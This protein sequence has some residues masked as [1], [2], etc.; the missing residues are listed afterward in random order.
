MRIFKNEISI[1][2]TQRNNLLLAAILVNILNGILVYGISLEMSSNLYYSQ[3]QYAMLFTTCIMFLG[4]GIGGWGYSLVKKVEY[5]HINIFIK[6]WIVTIIFTLFVLFEWYPYIIKYI[7]YIKLQKNLI[8]F[9]KILC[10]GLI[11]FPIFFVEGIL[12]AAL[13]CIIQNKWANNIPILAATSTIGSAFGYVLGIF[14]P[15]MP[16]INASIILSVVLLM[17]WVIFQ[18]KRILYIFLFIACILFLLIDVDSFIEKIRPDDN[19]VYAKLQNGKVI[20]YDWSRFQKSEYILSGQG[21]DEKISLTLNGAMQVI[22]SKNP[23]MVKNLGYDSIYQ[24]DIVKGKDVL[25]IGGGMGRGAELAYTNGAATIDIVDIE[26]SLKSKYHIYKEYNQNI[27]EKDNVNFIIADGR[28]I[29]HKLNKK[30][31]VIVF[32]GV[33]NAAA[34]YSLNIT[35]EGYLY[36]QEAMESALLL[37]KKDGIFIDYT[38]FSDKTIESYIKHQGLPKN[39]KAIYLYSFVSDKIAHLDYYVSLACVSENQTLLSKIKS[40]L[41][42]EIDCNG[43]EV[44]DYKQ[45]DILNSS[46]FPITDDRPF[47][48]VPNRRSV[49]FMMIWAFVFFIFACLVIIIGNI[50]NSINSQYIAFPVLGIGM[51]MMELFLINKMNFFLD[52]SILSYSI[53]SAIFLV[54]FS[55]GNAKSLRFETVDKNIFLFLFIIMLFL[56]FGFV[57]IN[58]RYNLLKI[59]LPL[60]IIIVMLVISPISFLCGTFF[61]RLLQKSLGIVNTSRSM[62]YIMILDSFG[63]AIGFF[64][65][66]Y[67]GSIMGFNY[68]IPVILLCYLFIIV[69]TMKRKVS[70]R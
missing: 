5:N 59:V 68:T 50:K 24:G 22:A 19:S 17:L 28:A 34:V 36:T 65:F 33:I 57:N 2:K 44:S 67:I 42:G 40:V 25:I 7:H 56:P 64:L 32:E 46:L 55:L 1:E 70:V 23:R 63:V 54:F 41:S 52:D 58:A 48:F 18:K 51:I 16:G 39:M 37:L 62:G 69:I 31:D 49:L 13:F 8:N 3:T 47:P 6:I 12:Y 35:T 14:I 66:N 45:L 15:I 30:Y 26:P 4:H 10:S 29:M 20:A 61:P 9:L 60:R 27:Y 43:I 38:V 21:G 53:V 11:E